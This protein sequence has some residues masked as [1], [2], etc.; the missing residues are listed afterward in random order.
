[1]ASGKQISHVPL[2]AY[3]KLSFSEIDYSE[4]PT[5]VV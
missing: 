4:N 1:M 3:I 2:D 5:L